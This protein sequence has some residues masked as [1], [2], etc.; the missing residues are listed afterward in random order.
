MGGPRWLCGVRHRR[1]PIRPPKITAAE[2]IDMTTRKTHCLSCSVLLVYCFLLLTLSGC[3]AYHPV[4][5]DEVPFKQHSLTQVEGNV[6]VT[7]GRRPNRSSASIWR[8]GGSRRSGLKLKIE[9]TTIIGCCLQHWIRTITL[10]P[11]LPIIATTGYPR[12]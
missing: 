3:A 5:I 9:T 1:D 7:A 11:R 12:V 10:P 8:C 4:A 6:R 2:E